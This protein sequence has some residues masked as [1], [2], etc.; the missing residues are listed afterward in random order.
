MQGNEHSAKIPA[1]PGLSFV[2]IFDV[3]V[4]NNGSKYSSDPPERSRHQ[5]GS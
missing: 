5:E 3:A 1:P 2:L 4:G